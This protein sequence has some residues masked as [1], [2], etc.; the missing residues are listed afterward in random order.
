[1]AVQ[2][3]TA[4]EIDLAIGS[5]MRAAL[6]VND[7]GD[8]RLLDTVERASARVEAALT[9]YGYTMPVPATVPDIVRQATLGIFLEYS[10]AMENGVEPPW[11]NDPALAELYGIGLADKIQT[12]AVLVPGMSVNDGAGAGGVV[13]VPSGKTVSGAA[14]QVFTAKD[15]RTI[16]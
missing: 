6:Y 10:Y 2:Y 15:M 12:G 16:F 1:M 3:I 14:W 13:S 9:S 5:T 8:A 11:L 7:T 4:G